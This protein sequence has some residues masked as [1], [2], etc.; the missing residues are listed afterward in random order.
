[1]L[2]ENIKDIQSVVFGFQNA[3]YAIEEDT[4]NKE[5]AKRLRSLF[6]E[7]MKELLPLKHFAYC[8]DDKDCVYIFDDQESCDFYIS[9]INRQLSECEDEADE[10][11]E[12]PYDEFIEIFGNGNNPDCYEL[13]EH[14]GMLEY[15]I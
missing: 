12:I 4:E 2:K 5:L 15:H 6:D 3:L 14:W 9:D 10:L 13:D 8:D 1:M 11:R 7:T